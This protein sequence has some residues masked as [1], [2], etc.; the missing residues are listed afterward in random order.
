VRHPAKR[1]FGLSR[2]SGSRDP[3]TLNPRLPSSAPIQ[4][5][6]AVQKL[7]QY[8]LRLSIQYEG[9]CHFAAG[10]PG[11]CGSSFL[12]TCQRGGCSKIIGALLGYVVALRV[13]GA[14]PI[15][16]AGTASAEDRAT[17]GSDLSAVWSLIDGRAGSE[18][19]GVRPALVGSGTGPAGIRPKAINPSLFILRSGGIEPLAVDPNREA[20]SAGR[21]N[22]DRGARSTR[23][24]ICG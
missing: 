6:G 8:T 18:V 23:G 16:Y 11:A 20:W 24:V 5:R 9:G 2:D 19:F 12:W 3:L 1:L 22:A 7:Q 13:A 17:L 14:W 4:R 21:P 15:D 10:E